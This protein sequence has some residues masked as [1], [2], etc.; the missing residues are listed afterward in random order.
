MAIYPAPLDGVPVA[1]K[2]SRTFART[3]SMTY[4]ATDFR[5]QQ[6]RPSA[7]GP[8]ACSPLLDLRLADCMA[9][10]REMPDNHFDL[11]IV[12]PPYSDET[13]SLDRLLQDMPGRKAAAGVNRTN[14]LQGHAPKEEYFIELKRVSVNQI[15]WGVNWFP[16]VFGIGRVVWDKQN[17]GS[18]FSDCEIAYQSFNRKTEKFT[19]RWNGMLQGDMKNKEKRIH[20]TQKPVA[21]YDWLLAKYAKPGDRILDTHMGSGSIAIACHYRGHPLTACEIDADY[22]AAAVERIERETRQLS[23]FTENDKDQAQPENHNQPSNT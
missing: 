10:M 11:A 21:L 5:I 16:R 20:P 13:K 6:P 22:Y 7:L 23:L 1:R 3:H 4:A 15:V 12:D 18:N 19:F 8:C 9:V 2:L 14:T 17:E